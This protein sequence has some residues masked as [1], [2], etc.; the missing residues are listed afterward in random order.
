[1]YEK[2]CSLTF[3]IKFRITNDVKAIILILMLPL[4]FL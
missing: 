1:M 3:Q 2:Y 4:P